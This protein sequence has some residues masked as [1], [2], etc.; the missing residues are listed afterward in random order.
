MRHSNQIYM[1]K[2]VGPARFPTNLVYLMKKQNRSKNKL[3]LDLALQ[4]IGVYQQ[5]YHFY[6]ILSPYP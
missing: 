3:A 6:R 4:Q 1:I 5:Y 2:L